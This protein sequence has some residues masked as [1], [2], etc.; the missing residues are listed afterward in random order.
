MCFLHAF[1]TC[2]FYVCFSILCRCSSSLPKIDV[3]TTAPKCLG[4][5]NLNKTLTHLLDFWVNYL[6]E[7][8]LAKFSGPN[9]LIKSY[10]GWTHS[11]HEGLDTAI[12]NGHDTAAFHHWE[13]LHHKGSFIKAF[14]RP[15]CGRLMAIPFSHLYICLYLRI[16]TRTLALYILDKV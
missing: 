9:P 5:R 12:P 7:I 4:S 3:A 14:Y 15:Y 16:K 13:I 6:L 2:V 1:F 10:I 11:L 8:M